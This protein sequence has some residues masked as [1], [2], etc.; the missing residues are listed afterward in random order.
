MFTAGGSYARLFRRQGTD[1]QAN[2]VCEPVP[3]VMPWKH[4]CGSLQSTYMKNIVEENIY[5]MQNNAIIFE[6]FAK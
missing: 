4:G 3:F 2:M 6:I 1:L 5:R